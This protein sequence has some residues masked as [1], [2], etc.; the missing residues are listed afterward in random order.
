MNRML[1]MK[2]EMIIYKKKIIYRIK[3]KKQHSLKMLMIN[4][5]MFKQNNKFH[6]FTHKN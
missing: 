5:I 6:L 3:I 1:K 4:G 2:L